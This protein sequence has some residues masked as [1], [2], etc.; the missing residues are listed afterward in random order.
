MANNMEQVRRRGG[1]LSEKCCVGGKQ[2]QAKGKRR[3]WRVDRTGKA[4]RLP[5]CRFG[6][7]GAN[8]SSGKPFALKTLGFQWCRACSP[9]L[10][11]QAVGVRCCTWER[12]PALSSWAFPMFGK[13]NRHL[14][15]MAMCRWGYNPG[16][17]C[18]DPFLNIRAWFLFWLTA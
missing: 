1:R 15:T 9:G 4:A 18:C 3:E 7:C 14:R 8:C 2:A 10:G 11:S 17:V 12:L 5:P 16:P 13:S 6:A